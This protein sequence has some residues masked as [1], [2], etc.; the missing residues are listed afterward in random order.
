[1]TG[2]YLCGALWTKFQP[3]VLNPFVFKCGCLLHY[4]SKKQMDQVEHQD[5][6]IGEMGINQTDSNLHIPVCCLVWTNILH[7]NIKNVLLHRNLQIPPSPSPVNAYHA[8]YLGKGIN[9]AIPMMHCKQTLGRA[10]SKRCG[11]AVSGFIGFMW[12]GTP[13]T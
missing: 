5:I 13:L 11:F 8:G 10:V 4:Y 2:S 6:I 1:M 12:T 9:S 7:T 3:D